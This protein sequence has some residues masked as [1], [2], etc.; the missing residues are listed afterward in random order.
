VSIKT[1]QTIVQY[2]NSTIY[3]DSLSESN[4][5]ACTAV[6]VVIASEMNAQIECPRLNKWR[7]DTCPRK[8]LDYQKI[9]FL[10][11]DF[12]R[13]KASAGIEFSLSNLEN[14]AG[15]SRTNLSQ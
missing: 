7:G 2:I 13:K 3:R 14:M 4:T 6:N 11:D 8:I 10:S 1:I 15:L 5:K 12:R 9:Y